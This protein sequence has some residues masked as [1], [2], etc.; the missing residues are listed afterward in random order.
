MNESE[1][2]CFF[3]QLINCNLTPLISS[4]MKRPLLLLLLFLL[5]VENKLLAQTRTI[6]ASQEINICE[7]EDYMGI[8]V[9]GIYVDTFIAV[10]GAIPF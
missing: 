7:G 3:L 4:D 1:Q 5:L 6:T 8:S 10:N 9:P 2:K